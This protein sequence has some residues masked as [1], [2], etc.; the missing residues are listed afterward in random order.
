MSELAVVPFY[1]QENEVRTITDE[2]GN[3][4]F[5][6][7]D[8]ATVLG[9]A[10]TSDAIGR[11]C[12]GVVRHYP[13]LTAGGMQDVRVILLPDLCR[14]IV[15]SQLPSAVEF[16]RWVFEEVLPSILH[17]GTYTLP[18]IFEET[19]ENRVIT[20][21]EQNLELQREIIALLKE[22]IAALEYRKPR[23][24]HRPLTEED[25]LQILEMVAS[26]M[27][28]NDVA[29]A[30]RRSTATVSMLISNRLREVQQ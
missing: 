4:L 20:L 3:A 8:V 18:A 13:L 30:V 6:A 27:S 10:N 11:H 26:G 14:L 16:E 21:Q 9:Y 23:Q 2:Q 12:K 29:K 7:K 19:E 17:T 1:F 22:K 28:Q 24:A 15:G 25:K 5:V